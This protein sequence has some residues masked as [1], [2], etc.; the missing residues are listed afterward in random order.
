MGGSYVFSEAVPIKKAGV[1]AVTGTAQ[2]I[3]TKGENC[4][5][6]VESGT[7]YI[8]NTD[9]GAATS[10]TGFPLHTGASISF[11]GQLSIIAATT[12]DVRYIYYGQ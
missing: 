12:A 8:Q 4:I 11:I 5:I 9:I 7:A 1:I 6:Y 3:D 10:A 2:T